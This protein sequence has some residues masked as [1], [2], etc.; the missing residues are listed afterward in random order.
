MFEC[1]PA[2]AHIRIDLDDVAMALSA[3]SSKPETVDE[4][5]PLLVQILEGNTLLQCSAAIAKNHAQAHLQR[6]ILDS[7]PAHVVLLDAAGT[8]LMVN[9]SW[10]Q[11]ASTHGF[12]ASATGIGANYLTA[13]DG[14]QGEESLSASRAAAGIRSVLQGANL[15][16]S[17]EYVLELAPGD[18]W[19]LMMVAPVG[20]TRPTG[21]AVMHLDITARKHDEANLWRFAAAMDSLVDGVFLIDRARMA[22]IYVNDAACRLHGWSRE[23]LLAAKLWEFLSIG[24]AEMESKYDR[25]LDAGGTAE[26]EEILWRR[27]DGTQFWAEIRRHVHCLD[28][29]VNVVVLVRDITTRKTAEARIH[30]LNRV[31]AVSS[32]INTLIVR[33]NNREEL[34]L[35]ACRIAVEK[36][37]FP[38]CWIGIVDRRIEKLVPVA[39]AGMSPEYLDVLT[40]RLMNS[41]AETLEPTYIISALRH[42]QTRVCND[43]RNDQ[44]VMLSADQHEAHGIRSFAVLPLMVADEA[45]GVL[46]LCAGETD[47]FHD[48]ELRLLAE[49]ASDV[50]FAVDHIE[51]QERLDYLAF[52]DSLTGLANRHLFLDRLTQF[53]RSA[54]ATGQRIAVCV[55]DLER[56]RNFND[57][58]GTA[59]GDALLKQVADW[60]V[61]H[62][63]DAMLVSRLDSDH[64]AVVLSEVE[65]EAEAV[66]IVETLINSFAAHTFCLDAMEYRMALKVG[67]AIFPDDGTESGLLFK[68]A[69]AALTKA[70]AS[71]D[72]Y[73]FYA[74]RMAD[75]VAGRLGM[76][77]RLRQALDREEFVLHYQPKI[78][79]AT[80]KMA[81]AEALLRWNDGSTG[82]VLPARFIPLLEETGL[83]FEVG[84]W[85]LRKAIEDHVQWRRAGYPGVRIAVNVSPLQLRHSSFVD[86]IQRYARTE[87][88]V[89]AGLELEVTETLIMED[90]KRS[91]AALKV[92]RELGITIAIDDFGTGYSSLS[93]LAK[94]PVDTLKIDRSFIYDMTAGPSG[95]SLVSTIINLAHSFNLKAVAEG[96]ETVEQAGMLHKL[97]CDEAQGYLYSKPLPATAFQKKY[98]RRVAS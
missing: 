79:L 30:Y 33:V 1:L 2:N 69:N 5:L 4:E 94:L 20:G 67:V 98:L 23:Q 54:E 26:A 55:T 49:L 35:E 39:S 47:F 73:L 31:H 90:V 84:R 91:I 18:A 81:G 11:F 24:R 58:L 22:L 68:N 37:G 41:S 64:F 82:L 27:A 3:P 86:D 50:S 63:G 78:N 80:G 71:R 92:I 8:I 46:A 51:K 21:A 95:R 62:V 32:G 85:V 29:A 88:C 87:D 97:T 38:V 89:S 56:F 7:L 15:E 74:L 17:M 14:V 60:L 28:G 34:F 72:P 44:Y 43:L 75:T 25:I 93:Q 42:K 45:V 16:F 40:E 83:I 52:F 57:S 59:A 76:E 65:N 6:E 48:E 96:V 53:I 13:C 9:E 66:R 10:N 61:G 19:F 12:H 36:G 77:N 70:K